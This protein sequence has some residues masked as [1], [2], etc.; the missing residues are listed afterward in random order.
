MT[1]TSRSYHA[2]HFKSSAKRST[3]HSVI[4]IATSLINK[5][6]N[7]GLKIPTS[8]TPED[9]LNSSE[10][11]VSYFNSYGA[12]HQEESAAPNLSGMESKL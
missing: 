2:L 12:T 3:G 1:V 9:R 5:L 7:S 8:R 4:A 10:K 6:N 11:T